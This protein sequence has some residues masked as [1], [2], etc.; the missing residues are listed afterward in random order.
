[1]L[2]FPL[3]INSLKLPTFTESVAVSESLRRSDFDLIHDTATTLWLATRLA[4][5]ACPLFSHLTITG[6]G[7]TPLRAFLHHLYRP[8]GARLFGDADAII[9]YV[10]A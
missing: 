10:C 8:V 2:R 4:A 7:H 3:T 9:W 6:T 1:M 5:A